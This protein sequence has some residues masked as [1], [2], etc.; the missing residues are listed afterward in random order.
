VTLTLNLPD[1]LAKEL[2]AILPEAERDR[3]AV[4]AIAEALA[5]R[6]TQEEAGLADALLAELDPEAEADRERAECRSVVEE[7]LADVDAGRDL[8]TFE[9]ARRQWSVTDP[10]RQAADRA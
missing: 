6:Q 1:E 5:E 4:S 10:G 3:F 9:E 7:G 8:V 2:A